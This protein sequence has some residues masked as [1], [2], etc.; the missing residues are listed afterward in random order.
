M[1]KE[2]DIEKS[3]YPVFVELQGK[4]CVVVGGGGIAER[5]VRTLLEHGAEVVVI[6]PKLSTGLSSL[7]KK[8]LIEHQRRGFRKGDS[9]GGLLVF[10]ATDS[11]KVNKTVAGDAARRSGLVNVVDTPELCSF[12]VPSI[13]RRGALSIA[14]STSGKSPALSKAIRKLLEGEL[15]KELEN[16]VSSLGKLREDLRKKI[17]G[18]PAKR[19]KKLTA[20][21]RRALTQC[22]AGKVKGGRTKCK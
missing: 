1:A 3:Y 12:I 14:I 17:P 16:H 15:S 2:K 8:G 13:V 7:K 21:A 20:A 6:S 22:R 5:K 11:A 18:A 9:K 19:K 4:R 10:A